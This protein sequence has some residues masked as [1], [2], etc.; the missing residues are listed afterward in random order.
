MFNLKLILFKIW[1]FWGDIS[2]ST[3]KSRP[4]TPFKMCSRS[5]QYGRFQYHQK[6]LTQ[7]WSYGLTKS[8]KLNLG[9]LGMGASDKQ[10]AFCPVLE[11]TP[12]TLDSVQ[13]FPGNVCTES[14]EIQVWDWHISKMQNS[15]ILC[16]HFLE[17]SAQNQYSQTPVLCR[18]FLEMSAQNLKKK[19]TFFS[20]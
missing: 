1:E 10:S 9:H 5:W 20:G 7:K 12:T 13:T 15:A 17:M 8:Q 16:R 14:P 18:H 4:G 6:L 11:L 19:K 2:T 3:N